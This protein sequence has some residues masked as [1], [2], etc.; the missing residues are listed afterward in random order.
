MGMVQVSS[1]VTTVEPGVTL[2][3]G[4]ELGCFQFGGSDFVIVF[5]GAGNVDITWQ[6]GVQE[7][8]GMAISR[9]YQNWMSWM[10]VFEAS[11]HRSCPARRSKT[12]I[13]RR[14]RRKRTNE[15]LLLSRH[16][17]DIEKGER[18]YDP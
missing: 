8:Q 4:E 12:L 10:I 3:T 16:R 7:R 11:T 18:R 1:I 2:H 14:V 6:A 15:K 5:E 9:V 13:E 17:N